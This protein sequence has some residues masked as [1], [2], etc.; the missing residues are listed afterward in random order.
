MQLR[1]QCSMLSVEFEMESSLLTFCEHRSLMKIYRDFES[2]CVSAFVGVVRT[3]LE[4]KR[5]EIRNRLS[6]SG[7]ISHTYSHPN[8]RAFVAHF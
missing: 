2:S 6:L 7:F 4:A 3:C 5:G 1:K 8:K